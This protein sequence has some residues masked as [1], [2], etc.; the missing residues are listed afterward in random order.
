MQNVNAVYLGALLRDQQ[1]EAIEII[2]EHFEAHDG[3]LRKVAESLGVGE[4][5]L[6]RWVKLDC[7]KGLSRR[8]RQD[9]GRNLP[10]KLD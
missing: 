4:R 6:H 7:L 8:T 3:N 9:S 2:R 1:P 5:T 10:K